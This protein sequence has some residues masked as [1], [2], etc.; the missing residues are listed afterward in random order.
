MTPRFTVAFALAALTASSAMA[1]PQW[2]PTAFDA[3]GPLKT[4]REAGGAACTI[5]RPAEIPP[6][7]PIV[8][9]GNGTGQMPGIYQPILKTLA[10]NGFVVAAANT[11]NAGNGH[12]MLGCLDWLTAENARAGGAYAG[13]LDLRKVGASG[14]SQGGG[15][16]LMA[17]RD[18]R[19]MTIAPIMPATRSPAMAGV[20]A[21]QHGPIL[22]LS[23]GAD[24]I[25]G[26]ATNQQPIFETATQPVF[27]ATLA[28]AGHLVP[29]GRG[30]VFPGI[31]NAWFRYRL[32]DDPKA[33]AM[34]EGQRC[35]YCVL[36]E[37]S[38]RRKSAG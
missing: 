12:D 3:M 19:V 15:G 17:G 4:V 37:W 24:A 28:G 1:Q 35:G 32:M 30:G 33:A 14:H 7:A 29:M 18:L 23:G 20:A 22:L 27:W 2:K 38:I 5:F 8:L 13:K 25:A 31:V 10:S 34:F 26:P 36:A 16:A 9:W 6:K 21:Q 11:P